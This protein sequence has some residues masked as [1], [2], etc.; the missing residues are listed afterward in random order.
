M[1]TISVRTPG[2]DRNTA[3]PSTG[4]AP[5]SPLGFL[6]EEIRTDEPTRRARLK[7]VV[8]VDESV[9]AGRM[10]NAAVC[11]AATT[12]KMVDGLIGPGGPDGSGAHHAGMPW[13][14]CSVLAAPAEAVA[15]VRARAAAAEGVLVV[16]MPAVAQATRVYDEYLG[17]L[18][19]LQPDDLGPL[20]V[21][22][23]GPR[24]KVDKIVKRLSLLS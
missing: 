12:G 22:I 3:V 20:A 4:A 17:E 8:V 18:A 24:N 7:W 15:A 9:P 6:P 21:S 23:I 16:D 1:T 11:V 5:G 10:V 19:A 2:T 13:A 14:G